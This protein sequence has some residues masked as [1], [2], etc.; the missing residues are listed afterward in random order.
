[1]P[2][3]RTP[4]VFKAAAASP[5]IVM[6]SMYVLHSVPNP[7]ALSGHA[8]VTVVVTVVVRVVTRVATV[9]VAVRVTVL[10]VLVGLH[11]ARVAYRARKPHI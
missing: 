1:M 4:P 9:V 8:V 7:A 3:R 11:G 10:P 5:D 6:L 2:H